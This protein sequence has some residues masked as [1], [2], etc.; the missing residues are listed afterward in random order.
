ML[1]QNRVSIFV[2]WLFFNLQ[3][4]P[5]LA[6]TITL[7]MVDLQ[8]GTSKFYHDLLKSSLEAIG[9]NLKIIIKGDIPKKRSVAMFETEKIDIIVLLRTP[10][11]NKK[12]TDVNIDLTSGMIGER[13]LFIPPLTTSDYSSIKTLTDFRRSGKVGVF[14]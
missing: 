14:G 4:S 10:K 2:L 11:R 6:D 13:V 3:T 7:R 8:E 9:H 12:Y 5:I 1:R